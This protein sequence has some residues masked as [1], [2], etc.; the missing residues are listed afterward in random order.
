PSGNEIHLDEKNKNMNFT[1]PETVT[2]NCK[3]FIINASE[4]ITYNAGT[5]IVI[6]A[7]RNITQRAENDINISAAGNINEHSNNRAEIIDKN[8]KRN[9]DISNEVASEVTIFSHTENMTLQSGKEI[10]LNS[11]EKTNFF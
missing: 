9:S 10:K 3:N 7:D 5:D 8:F 1:S 2:F 6:I 4:G 11:T